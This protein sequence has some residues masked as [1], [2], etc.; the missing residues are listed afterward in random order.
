MGP[1]GPGYR[2]PR[3]PGKGWVVVAAGGFSL[4]P[5]ER[6][7]LAVR[8]ARADSLALAAPAPLLHG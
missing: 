7:E 1:I 2:P 3:L 5:G 6:Y 8:G 4:V